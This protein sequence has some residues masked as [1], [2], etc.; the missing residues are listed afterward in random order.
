MRPSIA[1]SA[2]AMSCA[3]RPTTCG[4]KCRMAAA[5]LS[6]VSPVCIGAAPDSPQPTRPLSASIRTSTLSA[7]RMSSPA[8]M[9]GLR[10]GRLTAIGSMDF[11][12]NLSPVMRG[13]DPHIHLLAKTDG[14][15]GH[16]AARQPANDIES[17]AIRHALQFLDSRLIDDVLE[18]R[19]F[20]RDPRPGGVGA[21]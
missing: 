1:E 13:L 16:A 11:M 3:S 17:F 8:M 18:R 5:M 4:S 10:I 7:R 15:P 19:D 9:T 6:T 14:L 20:F 2:P 12:F 21:F